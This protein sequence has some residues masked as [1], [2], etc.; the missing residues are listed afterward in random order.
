[1]NEKNKIWL[2]ESS[3]ITK[4]YPSP[5]LA[6]RTLERKKRENF[7][8]KW[9]LAPTPPAFLE[10]RPIAIKPQAFFSTFDRFNDPHFLA[11]KTQYFRGQSFFIKFF[12]FSRHFLNKHGYTE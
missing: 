10:N 5:L 12:S 2:M 1:M 11:S 7:F 3:L 6:A 4:N 8:G 9:D